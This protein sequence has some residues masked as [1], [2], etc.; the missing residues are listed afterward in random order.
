MM[1][2]IYEKAHTMVIWLGEALPGSDGAME[3]LKQIAALE[4]EEPDLSEGDV[5]GVS[6]RFGSAESFVET[7]YEALAAVAKLLN[8]TY[9]D[10]AWIIQEA[11]TPKS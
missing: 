11:S 10:R 8:P 1:K 6:Y 9:W 3:L 5:L 4:N 2:E 7:S